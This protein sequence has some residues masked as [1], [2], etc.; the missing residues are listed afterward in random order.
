MAVT[1]IKN[2][3]ITD[4]TIFA[5]EKIAAQ[6]I[7][8]TL[9]NPNVTIAS[10]ITINGNLSVSGTTQT[11]N[12]VNTLINDPLVIFN[13]G[14]VGSPSYD[15]GVLVNRNLNP[16]NAAWIWREANVGFAGV[17]T[18]E[19]GTTTGSINNT[20]YANL[21][22][23]N[24]IIDAYSVN[25]VNVDTGAFQVRGGAGISANLNV[26]G[27]GSQFGATGGLTA[28]DSNVPVLQITQL[29]STRYGFMITDTNNNGALA[30]R[31]TSAK[32]AEIHT[33]GGTNKDIYIQPDRLK[34]I[35][36][37]AG[38]AAVLID[39]NIN[40]TL[41]NVGALNVTGSGGIFVGGNLNVG[42][43]ASFESGRV[44]I[45]AP[46][47]QPN[48]IALSYGTLYTG[49]GTNV[50]AVGGSIGRTSIG[51]RSTVFGAGAGNTAPGTDN[52]LVGHMAGGSVSGTNNQFFGTFAG[53]AISTGSYNV[54]I[55]SY[56]G[57]VIADQ[58]NQVVIADGAGAPRIRIDAAGNTF[59]VSGVNSTT[60]NTGAFTVQGG[61]GIGGNLNIGGAL[62]V[63]SARVILDATQ[64]SI[65]LAGN[66]AT[67][68]LA[69]DSVLIGQ[70]IGSGTIFGTK[71]TI[72]GS[73]AS[74][75]NNNATENTLIG[76]RAGYSG[77]G[78]QTTAIGSQAGLNLLSSATNNQL[79][80]YNAG[81]QITTGDYNVVLGANTMT[82][83]ETVNNNILI[84]DGQGTGRIQVTDTGVTKIFATTQSD[85]P[86]TGALIVYG[87]IGV[88]GN[89][90]VGGNLTVQGN[91]SVLGNT[92]TIGSQNLT[93]QDS[94]I[95]LHTF[96]N[97]APLTVDD[98]R[99][100]GIRTHYYKGTDQNSFFGFQN[101]TQNF[102][103]LQNSTEASGVHTGTYG[104]V[105]FGS[106]WLSNTTA[107][108]SQTSGAL[109]VKGGI[110]TGAL[111]YLHSIVVDN[112]ISATGTDAAI[113][114]SPTGTSGLVTINP[115]GIT[116]SINN[117]NIGTSAPGTG[118]FKDLFVLAST[119]PQGRNV[120]FSGNGYANLSPTGA[121]KISPQSSNGQS[122]NMDNVYI[123]NTT[124]R[125]ATFTSANVDA[126]FKLTSFTGNSVLFIDSAATSNLAITQRNENFNFQV[127]ANTFS[128]YMLSVGVAGDTQ[129]P[130]D[131][132]NIRYQGDAYNPQ[133]TI[134]ANTIGQA[135][136]WTVSTS[137]GTGTAPANVQTGDFNGVFGAYAYTGATA[138]YKETASWRFVADGTEAAS[139]G[140]GG[141]AQLWTKRDDGASTL[142]LRVD[143]NQIATFYGQVA[144]AN[145]TTSSTT[146]EGALYVQGGT[147]IG[148]NLN[149]S[150]GA[151]IN[152]QQNANRDFIVRGGNDATLIWANTRSAYNQ[153]LIGN[154]AVGANL[155]TGA[156]LQ[157][158]S[159]DSLM[160]P[161]G[162]TAQ[163]PGAAQGYGSATAGM[164]RF[165]SLTADLEYYT[166]TQWYSP[167]TSALTVV[168]DDQFSGN[169]SQ[170]EFIISR[171]ATTNGT[172]IT[173]NGVV[174]HPSVAY[175]TFSG[176]ST[177]VFT[178]A[179]AVGDAIDIRTVTLTSEVVGLSAPLGYVTV[180]TENESLKITTGETQA[181]VR[182]EFLNDGALL[183][184]PANLAVGQSQTI[185]DSFDK[186]QIRS[187][188]YVISVE[189]FGEYETSEIMVLHD[190]TTAYRTQYNKI[191]TG[192]AGLGSVTAA[193]V[194]SNVYVYYTGTYTSN[195][196]K[197]KADYM[198]V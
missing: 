146:T 115:A 56:D 159:T 19:T 184:R 41:A 138:G 76:Y 2:N 46:T 18:S 189:H 21:I 66:T 112:S 59:V 127:T 131:T 143:A 122:S 158:N 99:D 11:I 8:G 84:S 171:P 148:G 195:Y 7:V 33:F 136:G 139:N 64:T 164:I 27:T 95:E 39:N 180:V 160:I 89:S 58:N 9:F 85:S 17:L 175:N 30:L 118:Y 82:G 91:L 60:A 97:L 71:S 36:L 128:G 187:A 152:D 170:T 142:A 109:V 86:A 6:T 196:V 150:Q 179:P 92:V 93:V 3:Q 75:T 87:G 53:N 67:T 22:I 129:T 174:Q 54:I 194:G 105:Q 140:I 110:G 166:G 103:W 111:S 135:P 40:S 176:N 172:F 102:V 126:D 123:G 183:Y 83:L 182:Y 68:Y 186:T 141:Q 38:N 90:Y 149:V 188:K 49:L 72:V 69:A 57:N 32:G 101:S 81:S 42:T 23:G 35:W 120:E 63:A 50:T 45:Q 29:G 107:S 20:T 168:T 173:L 157:I 26:G 25:S 34:S 10:N 16:I 96:A 14:Y 116:G 147:S 198:G 51:D 104:N 79:F 130:T 94:I 133:S 192:N 80:G 13:N 28:I 113:T 119:T 155:V 117:M 62:G 154:S 197:Y 4:A 162:T 125:Q 190:G 163:R 48:T 37:P 193:V 100:V 165:N 185:V 24:T 88:G 114:F 74:N 177:V 70:K 98:G 108:G 55:G 65:V 61:A 169:G 181:N 52:T 44:Y 167:Q 145:S 78:Q 5:N 12:S 153:V 47:T 151:R 124:P 134:A 137:R 121:V 132:F 15:V 77:A 31:T 178:E 43:S 1:R 191:F 161:V 144:I 106:L 156:K 73:E